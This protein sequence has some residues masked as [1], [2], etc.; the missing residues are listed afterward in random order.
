MVHISLILGLLSKEYKTMFSLIRIF[1][2]FK[3][4][5]AQHTFYNGSTE[6]TLKRNDIN[7]RQNTGPLHSISNPEEKRKIIGDMFVKVRVYFLVFLFVDNF[8]IILSS[9]FSS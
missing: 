8:H 7:I 2:A 4:V 5:N 3:V 9:A 6:I 1:F